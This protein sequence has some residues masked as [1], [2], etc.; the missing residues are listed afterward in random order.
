MGYNCPF[1]TW[2]NKR[3]TSMPIYKCLD[4]CFANAE[5]CSVFPN[6]L[7]YNLPIRHS[8]HAP[9]LT[10]S[11]PTIVKTKRAFKFEN[12][13]LFEYDYHETAKHNWASTNDKPYHVRTYLLAGS[14]KKM[15]HK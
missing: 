3:F 6:T 4:R 10:I 8:D 11:K 13:W 15:E 2:C 7:V 9:I 12:W 14:L 5:W 1:F